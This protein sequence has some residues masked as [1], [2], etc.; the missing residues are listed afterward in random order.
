M[1]RCDAR[2]QFLALWLTRAGEQF[3]DRLT[4]GEAA[5]T[6]LTARFNISQPIVSQH[7]AT[8]R[9]AGRVRER[10]Q[11]RFVYYRV[12]AKG[13]RPLF[14]WISH[15]QAFW[16]ERLER[17]QTLLNE[18]DVMTTQAGTKSIS[19]GYDLPHPPEKVWRALTD[20]KLLT[21]WLMATDLQ[22]RVGISFTFKSDP[23]PWWDGI[24][25][26]QVLELD[27]HKRLS[28]SWQSGPESSP[29]DTV[30]SWTLTPT[31][32]GALGSR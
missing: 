12:E 29:L 14:D 25:H 6:D 7:L 15:Y 1:C 16:L 5:V 18:V 19:L 27:L 10:R 8:L 9:S 28:Y 2:T 32:S 17:L 13:L 31:S 22:P 4:R 23:T 21:M 26:C 20:P 24:V 11:G 3:Y 30:V